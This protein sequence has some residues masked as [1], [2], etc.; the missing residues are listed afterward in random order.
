[1]S[2]P[3]V[4]YGTVSAKIDRC[5]RLGSTPPGTFLTCP[6]RSLSFSVSLFFFDDGGVPVAGDIPTDMR[7]VMQLSELDLINNMRSGRLRV[8]GADGSL[9]FMPSVVVS[10]A[11]DGVGWT[12]MSLV[13]VRRASEYTGMKAEAEKMQRWPDSQSSTLRS[14]ARS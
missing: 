6:N 4:L 11:T 9:C 8:D 14:I 1:M 12:S 3:V 10:K 13:L 7:H 5:R 2:D